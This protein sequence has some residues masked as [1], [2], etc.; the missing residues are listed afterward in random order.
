[1]SQ[2]SNI[3]WTD[4]TWNPC[5]GCTKASPGCKNCYAE[6]MAKRLQG[7]KIKE[8]V[9]GFQPTMHP[10]KLWAPNGW[11]KPKRI[12]VGSMTDLFHDAF[13]VS[14]IKDVFKVMNY[15]ERHTFQV[16]TKRPERMAALAKD[17]LWT[18]NIWAG[19]SVENADYAYRIDFL[20]QVPCEIRFLSVEPLIGPIPELNISGIS[21]VIVGGESGWGARKME[22][23]WVRPIR[24]LCIASQTPFFFKQW[25]GTEKKTLGREL[26]GRIWNEFPLT[27]A[28]HITDNLAA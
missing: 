12:F 26:D 14:F 11:K 21:W 25:G 2:A 22:A 18:P 8:Y 9:N 28:I 6:V 4:A 15:N 10:S 7:K 1:M 20:R 3:E 17:L 23:D 19:T 24:D 5:T 16:L 13:P 27:T